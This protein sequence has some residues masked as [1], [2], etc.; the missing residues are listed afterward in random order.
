[1]GYSTMNICMVLADRFF[2]PDIRVEKEAR[3]LRAAGYNITIVSNSRDN[4]PYRDT[5]EGCTI[6]RVPTASGLKNRVLRVFKNLTF[7]DIEWF[8]FIDKVITADKFD[9]IHVHDLPLVGPMIRLGH[10]HNIPVIADLHE[11]YPGMV[12]Q[13]IIS[14]PKRLSNLFA[15]E[16]WKSY[17]RRCARAADHILV[18]ID[19]AKDRLIAEGIDRDKITIIENTEDADYFQGIPLDQGVIIHYATNFVISYIGGFGPHRGLDTAVKSMPDILQSIPNAKLLLVGGGNLYTEEL[20]KLVIELS[21]D[22]HVEIIPWQPFDKVP[23]Y[24]SLSDV[25]LVPHHA[26]QDTEATI[27]HKIF[28]YMLLGKPIVVSSSRPLKRIVEETG[29][30]LVYRV[31]DSDGLAHEVIRLKDENLRLQLGAA[32]RRAALSKYNWALTS[33]KLLKVYGQLTR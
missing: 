8:R 15:V 21:L 29:C 12:Q 31:S 22:K 20:K 13:F 1:M 27:P 9:L 23:T 16:R 2:P 3:A 24:I 28:Q 6:V 26:T 17:E 25:C 11:N 30:G 18:V 7:F 14:N 32:G 4:H 5:W 10:K 19:E 33:R